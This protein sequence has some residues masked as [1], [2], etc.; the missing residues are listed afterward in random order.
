LSSLTALTL[1]RPGVAATLVFLHLFGDTV[2]QF[3]GRISRILTLRLVSDM[4]S[5]LLFLLL[6][7]HAFPA[8]IDFVGTGRFRDLRLVRVLVAVNF[9]RNQA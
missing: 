1:A 6:I 9:R 2:R 8:M 5:Q 7:L 4:I 3:R